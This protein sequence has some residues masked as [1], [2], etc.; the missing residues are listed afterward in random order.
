M[1]ITLHLPPDPS[2]VCLNPVPCRGRLTL[3]RNITCSPHALG[4]VWPR[5]LPIRGHSAGGE[6]LKGCLVTSP[7]FPQFCVAA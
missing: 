7:A 4:W 3:T 5:G 2:S 1:L 6:R